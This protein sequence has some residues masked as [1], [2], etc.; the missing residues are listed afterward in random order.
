MSPFD[1]GATITEAHHS[2]GSSAG[3]MTSTTVKRV[4]S[5]SNLY[6]TGKGTPPR[7]GHAKWF[8]I[9][10]QSNVVLSFQLAKPSKQ[11]WVGF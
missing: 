11:L 9:L 1:F 3:S 8:C 4:I 5:F 6:R 10:I 2:V 7:G